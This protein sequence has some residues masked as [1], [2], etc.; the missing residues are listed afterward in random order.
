MDIIKDKYSASAGGLPL[1]RVRVEV[2]AH[3]IDRSSERCLEIWLEQGKNNGIGLMSF[4]IQKSRQAYLEVLKSLDNKFISISKCKV[5]YEGVTYCFSTENGV[6][7]LVT[8]YMTNK[9]T[10]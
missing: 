3:A 2:S 5:S 8:I 7:R 6:T 4:F 1:P 10:H 9:T